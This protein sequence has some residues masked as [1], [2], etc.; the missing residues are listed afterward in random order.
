MILT[1]MKSPADPKAG[2]NAMVSVLRALEL[3]A[4]AGTGRDGER[5]EEARLFSSFPFVKA[6]SRMLSE[7]W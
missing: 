3:K 5:L 6:P 4:G 7:E 2:A 1:E